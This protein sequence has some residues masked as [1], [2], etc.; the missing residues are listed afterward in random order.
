MHLLK[1]FLPKMGRKL[2]GGSS[3]NKLPKI[4]LMLD[5]TSNVWFFFS[6]FLC[7]LTCLASFLSFFSPLSL[8]LYRG[9]SFLLLGAHM[10]IFS[11]IFVGF[12]FCF[13][14]YFLEN[15]FGLIFYAIFFFLTLMKCPFIH[16]FLKIIICYFL[17]YLIGT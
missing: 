7:L 16:N 5:F 6:F 2:R 4:P 9:V 3:W 8:I 12:C 15:S 10:F 11:L 14:F 1:S 17:F 13:C